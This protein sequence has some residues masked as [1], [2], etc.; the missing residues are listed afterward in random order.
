MD[1]YALIGE[2]L[3]HSFSPDYFNQKFHSEKIN[4]FYKLIEVTK[5]AALNEISFW[6]YKGLNVTIPYKKAILKSCTQID[7]HTKAIGAANTLKPLPNKQLKG[8]NTDWIGFKNSLLPLLKL[9]DQSALIL[10]TGGSSEAVIYALKQLGI[11]IY[12]ASRNPKNDE[13][14][15]SELHSDFL[16]SVQLIINTTPV[17]M[18]P[19]TDA[20]PPVPVSA[21]TKK[22]LVYDLI[23]NPNPTLLLKQALKAGCRVKSGYEMLKLQAEAS[24]AVWNNY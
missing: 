17:G 20:L 12:V 22:H 23:Y 11:G 16:N 19:Q 9:T 18:Y 4:A 13:L 24:W 5:E 7:E 21:L 10:G 14:S 3:Q 1:A 2:S 6:N 15:Y 8:F